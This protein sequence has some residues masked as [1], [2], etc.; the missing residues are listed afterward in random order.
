MVIG[1][2]H[3]PEDD[4]ERFIALPENSD[5]LLELIDGEVVERL[6]TEAQGIII[7]AIGAKIHAFV[8][9]QNFGRVGVHILHHVPQDRQ[10]Y[11]L[12]DISFTADTTTPVVTAGAVLRLPDLAVEVKSPS[13]KNDAA[14]SHAV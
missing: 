3:Q 10:N 11:R 7:L 5:R 13:E 8:A 14:Q 2:D 4:F 1:T 12:P 6:P 9:A